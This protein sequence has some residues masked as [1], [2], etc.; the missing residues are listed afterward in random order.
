MK[1]SGRRY[2]AVAIAMCLACL[3]TGCGK[4]SVAEDL[5]DL[6]VDSSAEAGGEQGEAGSVSLNGALAKKLGVPEE[7]L[8]YEIKT[9]GSRTQ[10]KVDAEVILSSEEKVGVYEYQMSDLTEDK[11][12]GYARDLFDG[13]NYEQKKPYAAYTKDE[14]ETLKN[15]VEKEAAEADYTYIE[16][17]WQKDGQIEDLDFYLN[18]YIEPKEKYEEGKYYNC[19]YYEAARTDGDLAGYL[20]YYSRIM[21]LEGTI[22]GT[23]Y[24]LVAYQTDPEYGDCVES[25]MRLYRQDETWS[26]CSWMATRP[27]FSSAAGSYSNSDNICEISEEEARNSA[28]N[29]MGLLGFDNMEIVYTED[30]YWQR[31]PKA[32]QAD[33]EYYDPKMETDGYVFYLAKAY[34]GT[35]GMYMPYGMEWL[36]TDGSSYAKQ[37]EYVVTVDSKGVLNVECGPV[38]ENTGTVSEDAQ[39]L[40]FDEID[41]KAKEIFEQEIGRLLEAE[42]DAEEGEGGCVVDRGVINIKWVRLAYMSLQYEGKFRLTPVWVYASNTNDMEYPE[43]MINALDKSRVQENTDEYKCI[44]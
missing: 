1:K 35:S 43:V 32:E 20:L 44:Q 6:G 9:D 40:A 4:K 10:Y 14:L 7:P 26:Q 8:N 37:E 13:G 25:H 12:M 33:A 19:Q 42:E 17:A 34:N 16:D 3:A 2:I 29:C 27:H 22:G 23:P 28:L 38:Y 39:L 11:V 41:E 21:I 30:L 36:S 15:D 18:K 5:Q 31:T 24:Q